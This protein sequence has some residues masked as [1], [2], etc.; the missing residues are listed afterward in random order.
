MS[1]RSGTRYARRAAKSLENYGEKVRWPT[2]KCRE[3]AMIHTLDPGDRVEA[4]PVYGR[5]GE[6]IG[7]SLAV[8]GWD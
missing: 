5:D 7:P 3:I 1:Q 8:Q 4:A 6:R 2:K